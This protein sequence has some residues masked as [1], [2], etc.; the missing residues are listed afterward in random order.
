MENGKR[1]VKYGKDSYKRQRYLD[2]ITGKVCIDP[3]ESRVIQPH[4]KELAV[5]MVCKEGISFRKTSRILNVSHNS[6]MRWVDKASECVDF[7]DFNEYD[8]VE[9]VEVDEIYFI[10]NK[11]KLETNMNTS[12]LQ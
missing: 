4:V 11:K 7:K 1:Y 6:V 10:T 5:K 9:S 8:M 3:A 12:M 2:K